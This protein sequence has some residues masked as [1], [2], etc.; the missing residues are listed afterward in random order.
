MNSTKTVLQRVTGN[1]TKRQ[2]LGR[3]VLYVHHQK[4]V[5]HKIILLKYITEIVV[6]CYSMEAK[7]NFH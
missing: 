4:K 2:Q 6:L 1:T 5:M 7:I 3:A